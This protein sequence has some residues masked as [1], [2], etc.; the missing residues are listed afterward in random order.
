MEGPQLKDKG[1][2]NSGTRAEALGSDRPG[3]VIL[4]KFQIA[5]TISP[6]VKRATWSLLTGWE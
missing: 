6:S 5:A 4:G 3:W 2:K 1:D